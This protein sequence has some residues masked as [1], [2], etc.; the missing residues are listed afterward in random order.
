[1]Q[2]VRLLL[3]AIHAEGAEV[4]AEIGYERRGPRRHGGPRN[5]RRREWLDAERPRAVIPSAVESSAL[6]R[7]SA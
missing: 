5:A 7:A 3:L 1:M 4:G 2:R 6:L